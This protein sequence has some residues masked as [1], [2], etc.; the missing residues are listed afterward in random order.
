MQVY[1][2]K[3]LGGITR[4]KEFERKKLAS[5]AV[6]VGTK[7]GHDCLY[8]STGALL[9]MHRSFVEVGQSPFDHGYAI[10]D[11]ST[12]ERVSVDARRI[13]HRGVVQLCTTVD[14]WAP[15]A[16]AHQLGR[17]CLEAIL[18][19][20]GW[21]VRIL[22]KSASVVA[23]YDLVARYRDRVLVALSITGTGENEALLRVIEP[24]AS[25]IT[26][27]ISAMARAR[28][29]GLRTFGMFCPLIPGVA[30]TPEHVDQ[31]INLAAGWCAE[32]VF[33]EPV[34]P[35][36]PGL[37]LA[38]E[39]LERHGYHEQARAIQAVRQRRT[40]SAYVVRLLK[41]VQRSMRRHLEISRLRFLLYPSGLTPEDAQLIRGDDSGVVWLDKP[42]RRELAD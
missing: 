2:T 27:R 40:W 39:A 13:R 4:T 18:S 23:D 31:L 29:L 25:T 1:E 32:E 22:T 21:S 34:N 5:F 30:D 7:C 16:Q 42:E 26:E 11:P 20:P 10:V 17:R 38:Q 37:R 33:V 8:C 3:L 9:R 28:A 24:N 14:A 12:P 19:E 36:G 35:R 6:N 41:H 15:E